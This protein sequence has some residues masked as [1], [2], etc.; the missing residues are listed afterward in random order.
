M[1]IQYNKKAGIE[2]INDIA[3]SISNALFDLPAGLWEITIGKPTRTTKQNS[4]MHLLFS[5]VADALN[6][7]GQ[8][9]SYKGFK[10]MEIET[11]WDGEKIKTYLWKPIM[12]HMTGKESTTKLTTSEIDKIFVPLNKAFGEKG[13]SIQ[14]P[15]SFSQYLEKQNKN[16]TQG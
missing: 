12:I 7:E 1:K 10:G 5:Q 3:N 8:C 2:D 13:I 9:F 4:A 6:N 14:F 11:P 16:L 15:S